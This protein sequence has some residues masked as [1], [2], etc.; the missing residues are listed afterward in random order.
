M[1]SPEFVD[2]RCVLIDFSWWDIGGLGV[3]FDSFEFC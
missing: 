1:D 3:V 2:L